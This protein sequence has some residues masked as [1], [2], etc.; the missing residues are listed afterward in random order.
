VSIE[1][2]TQDI[3]PS[4]ISGFHF[5]HAAISPNPNS[6]SWLDTHSNLEPN[7]HCL[8]PNCNTTHPDTSTLLAHW[9]AFHLPPINA[10]SKLQSPEQKHYCLWNGCHKQVNRPSD[11]DRHVQSL[12]L[13]QHRDCFVPGCANN[14]G[15]GFM[16]QD[17]LRAHEKKV[18]RFF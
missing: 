13:G 10:L 15:R 18:H 14:G 3:Q 2:Q 17:K 11:L 7:L 16:R 12:H 6:I 8:W 9:K 1:G 5:N 4:I